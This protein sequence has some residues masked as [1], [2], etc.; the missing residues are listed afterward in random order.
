MWLRLGVQ[1]VL[2]SSIKILPSRSKK[3]R[4]KDPHEESKN[5]YK[6]SRHGDK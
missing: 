6:L 3:N 2:A 5:P 1:A 4:K